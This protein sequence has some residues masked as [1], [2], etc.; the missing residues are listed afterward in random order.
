MVFLN[1]ML[2]PSILYSCETYYNL[3][4]K[5]IRELERIEENFLRKMFKTSRGCPLK[6][7]YLEAGHQ[8]ARFEV[9]KTRLLFLQYI[10]QEGP[11]SRIHKF[12]QLQLQNPIRGDWGS[13]CAGDLR[14]LEINLSFKDIQNLNSIQFTKI[15]RKAIK[16]KAF[17]YL[18]NKR[19]KK[20]Q[21]IEY[22]EQKMAEYLIPNFKNLSISDKRKI[23]E[24]RNGMLP[25]TA[26]FPIKGEEKLC[27]NLIE[28][29]KHIY[30]CK[31]WSDKSEK[32]N[33]EK[34]YTD[35]MNDLTKVYKHYMI[36]LTKK[37]KFE[38][39]QEK[40]EKELRSP[41]AIVQS[42]P[43]FSVIEYSNGNKH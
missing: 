21:E 32:P 15:L 26:N 33:F 27:C 39:E 7:L 4:E 18:S 37:E 5:E 6:Q 24:I 9:K 41:H 36:H 43:L 28:D 1:V 16:V 19:G 29:T 17:E 25:I 34:I 23:F 14:D 35:N 42:D 2:R 11:E 22:T 40:A 3:K 30:T 20:G 13:S 38:F 8:P 12:L 31:Y 10:L